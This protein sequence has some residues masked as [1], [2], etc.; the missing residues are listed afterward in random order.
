MFTEMDVFG[1]LVE[2]FLIPIYC[3][4]NWIWESGVS[5]LQISLF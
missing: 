4:D 5:P 1:A 3:T 2:E